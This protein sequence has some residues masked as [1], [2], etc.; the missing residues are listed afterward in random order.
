MNGKRCVWVDGYFENKN[1]TEH[2]GVQ[3]TFVRTWMAHDKA[4]PVWPESKYVMY[5]MR[6][7]RI[8][9][10]P[11]VGIKNTLPAPLSRLETRNIETR[12]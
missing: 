9:W 5:Q 12:R 3:T 6:L 8:F 2:R 11:D 1:N 4:C 10:L 7:Y